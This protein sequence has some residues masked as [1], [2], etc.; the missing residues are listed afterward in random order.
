MTLVHASALEHPA[1][2]LLFSTNDHLYLSGGA[3]ADLLGR[4]GQEIQD[5]LMNC[6]RRT[7]KKF[8]ET[9]EVIELRFPKAPWKV[10]YA[11]VAVDPFYHSTEAIISEV[12]Q[13]AFTLA[14]ANHFVKSIVTTALGTGYG[15]MSIPGFISTLDKVCTHD[16]PFSVTV[17]FDQYERYQEAIDAMA[18]L[19]GTSQ[20]EANKRR[21][22]DA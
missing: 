13:R 2:A 14:S 22:A 7:G 5:E 17:A 20:L 9:G 18:V 12:L 15:D 10:I 6:L 19:R 11:G 21:Q 3:G 4:F 16:L 1:D 8:A